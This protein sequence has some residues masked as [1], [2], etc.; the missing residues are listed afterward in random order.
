MKKVG[1]LIQE[2]ALLPEGPQALTL[3]KRRGNKIQAIAEIRALREKRDHEY[4]FTTSPF[5]LCSFPISQMPGQTEYVRKN[6]RHKLKIVAESEYG[7]PWGQ[8]RLIPIWIIT[9][10]MRTGDRV[11]RFENLQ[12]ILD[13]FGL[14]NNGRN[15][16]RM[17]D[18]FRRI[19]AATII[20]EEDDSVRN[21]DTEKE[22]WTGIKFSFIDAL[23]L[24]R[25]KG[26]DADAQLELD[27]E[28]DNV[29]VVSE[30]LAAQILKQHIPIDLRVV[31]ALTD[32]PSALDLFIWLSYRCFSE[33]GTARI[34]LF[35]E[36]GLQNQFGI[37]EG[38]QNKTFKQN[39]KRWLSVV[40]AVWPDCPATINRDYLVVKNGAFI[41]S[42]GK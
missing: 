17:Q 33:K 3:S 2:T 6:G 18:A 19:F 1:E 41:Q 7:L 40:K 14:A 35:G 31:R 16:K 13:M 8:D 21:G 23:Q 37:P 30:A 20:W 29:V 28:M 10:V 25:P 5:V 24:S 15:H 32:N 4:A 9:E 26:R 42:A 22:V 38:T 11:I 34:P 12:Q 39:L 27:M 36:F